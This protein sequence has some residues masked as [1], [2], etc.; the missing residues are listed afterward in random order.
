M[1]A[2]TLSISPLHTNFAI[3]GTF[4][5]LSGRTLCG[6]LGCSSILETLQSSA[7][8]V[9]HALFV[10][11]QVITEEVLGSALM[12]TYP[13]SVIETGRKYGTLEDVLIGQVDLGFSMHQY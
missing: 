12:P 9:R 5:Q 3:R 11:V 1:K 6:T 2:G 7:D 4:A 8:L 10:V 13:P